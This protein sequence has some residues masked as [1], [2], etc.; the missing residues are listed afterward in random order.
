M[1]SIAKAL[2]FILVLSFAIAGCGT[3]NEPD[4]EVAANSKDNDTTEDAVLSAAPSVQADPPDIEPD[5]PEVAPPRPDSDELAG[6]W[7]RID[8]STAT[9]PLTAALYDEL[10]GG[11]QPPFHNT[12]PHAYYRLIEYYD[13]DLVFVT[14]PSE[15][16]FEHASMMCQLNLYNNTG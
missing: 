5:V 11:D 1:K 12:T 10:C 6:L 16:E 7:A 13:I 9:I 4:D 3:S 8:G 2:V 15:N 14:Y